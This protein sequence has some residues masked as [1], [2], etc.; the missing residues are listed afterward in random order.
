MRRYLLPSR[1]VKK[2]PKGKQKDLDYKYC[3]LIL[4][5]YVEIWNYREETYLKSQPEQCP[6][7]TDIEAEVRGGNVTCL[8]QKPI[9]GKAG[10]RTEIIWLAL[11]CQLTLSVRFTCVYWCA[12]ARLEDRAPGTKGSQK[13]DISTR[14]QVKYS[15]SAELMY[16]TPCNSDVCVRRKLHSVFKRQWT[17]WEP[18][19]KDQNIPTFSL[20]LSCAQ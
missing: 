14:Q 5:C 9:Y 8:G 6:W 20:F 16:R 19:L 17:A 1:D 2:L 13:V 15:T 12:V 10:N 4:F 11:Y 7:F 3:L 18:V